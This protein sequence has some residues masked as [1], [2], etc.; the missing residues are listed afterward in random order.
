MRTAVS[1]RSADTT[2]FRKLTS[3][4]SAAE[5]ATRIASV[6]S[7]LGMLDRSDR[8]GQPSQ[9]GVG[10]GAKRR[11]EGESERRRILADADRQQCN[12]GAAGRS[13]HGL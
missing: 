13:D 8:R 4:S 1:S 10:V 3:A 2:P 9:D 11:L 5:A 6:P 7:G 12:P